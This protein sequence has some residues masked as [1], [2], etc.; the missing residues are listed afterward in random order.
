M[1]LPDCLTVDQQ[2]RLLI[3][4]VSVLKLASDYGTPLYIMDE[5]QIEQNG[6]AFLSALRTHYG[7][8]GEIAFASKAF[9]V[10]AM[11]RTLQRIG[12]WSDV[13]S[14]GELHTA[15]KAGFDPSH[16][17][18]HGNS[19]TRHELNFAIFSDVGRIIVDN[20]EELALLDQLALENNKMVQVGIRIRPGVDAHTHDF[21]TTGQLDSKFGVPIEGGLAL[22]FIGEVLQKRNLTL[23]SLHCH[24]GSQIFDV[25]PFAFTADVMLHLMADAK[26]CFGYEIPELNLGG[27]F[28][29]RYTE[30]DDPRSI[31][32][33]IAASAAAVKASAA[34]YALSLPRLF[35][36]PG[37]SMVAEAGITVYETVAVKELPGL[38]IKNYILVD[39][40]MGDNPR[41]VLYGA[42]YAA[43]LPSRVHAPAEQ[44][45]TVA[46]RCCESG[47][48][49]V[50][51]CA[52]PTVKAGELI[53]VLS[54]GAYNY[55]M[56]SNYN[57]VPRPPVVFV[58]DGAARL[59]VR[60]ETYDDVCQC[61]L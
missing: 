4:G 2:D 45:Y 35:F 41:Y 9:S 43:V 14:G 27:G 40:G 6:R 13:V 29:I 58:K 31:D 50:A 49:V 3:G 47:D 55:S 38:N 26:A 19:K 15:L 23:A 37:R 25:E 16:L 20:I 59:V 18:F 28:G 60:R 10:T 34:K 32:A 30:T 1:F 36:E 8:N 17:I 61:D 57:R 21:I 46:G 44:T 52:L 54:T 22:D 56:A 24:I 51:S 7:E 11:Y 42:E 53:A 12:L 5:N 39:G 48:V 33:C